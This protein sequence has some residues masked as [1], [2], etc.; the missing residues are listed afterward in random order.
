[1]ACLAELK[2]TTLVA[3]ARCVLHS[4]VKWKLRLCVASLDLG[5]TQIFKDFVDF[6]LYCALCF[7]TSLKFYKLCSVG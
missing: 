3:G 4:L 1:M 7:F 2:S 5:K 6:W